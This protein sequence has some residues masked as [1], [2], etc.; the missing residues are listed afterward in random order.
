MSEGHFDSFPVETFLN[1]LMN[2]ILQGSQI[3]RRGPYHE[4]EID[5]RGTE[6]G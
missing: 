2:G 1:I 6:T 5:G 4:D 3:S